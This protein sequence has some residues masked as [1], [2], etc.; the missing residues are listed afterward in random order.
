MERVAATV[1]AAE[2]AD[3]TRPALVAM[4]RLARRLAPNADPDDVVQESLARAWQKRG[5]FDPARGTPTTWLLAILADQARSARRSRVRRLRVV[6]DAAELPDAPA[7]N[8]QPD[9][10]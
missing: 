4:S 6:D 2:F 5:Q 1:D 3:W 10:D 8:D 7:R 9:V